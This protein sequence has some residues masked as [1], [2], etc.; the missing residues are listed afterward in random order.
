MKFVSPVELLASPVELKDAEL[1][2]VSA[3]VNDSDL[4]DVDVNKNDV[5]VQAVVVGSDN[6]QTANQ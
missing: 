6:K 2:A 3:G 5:A 4:V 1:D